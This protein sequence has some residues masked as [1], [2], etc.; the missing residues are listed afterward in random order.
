MTRDEHLAWCKRRALEYVAIGD[1]QQALA[2]MISGLRKHPETETHCG[3]ELGFMLMMG[4]LLSTPAEMK[5]FIEG[6]N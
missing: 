3:I 2:S 5:K 1:L 6:F 4:G